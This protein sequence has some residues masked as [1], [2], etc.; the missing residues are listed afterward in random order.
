MS[1][2][3]NSFHLSNSCVFAGVINSF[4]VFIYLIIGELKSNLVAFLSSDQFIP[5]LS[6]A[7]HYNWILGTNKLVKSFLYG[8]YS[9]LLLLLISSFHCSLL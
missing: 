4:L 1:H 7:L 9:L 8:F 5:L 3:V 2:P 6:A